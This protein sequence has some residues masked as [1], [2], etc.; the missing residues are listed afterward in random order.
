M[1]ATLHVNTSLARTA[2]QA[3]LPAAGGVLTR[4]DDLAALPGFTPAVMDRLRPFI[5]LLPEATAV[6]VNTAEAEVLTAVATLTLP[7][8]RQLVQA[9]AQAYFKDNS[10]FAL[11]LNDAQTLEG[12]RFDV[13]SEYFLVASE[14]RLK[15]TRLRTEALV[16]RSAATTLLWVR[17]S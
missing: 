1:L 12:V 10:D 15:G 14:V 2:A 13:T 17:E 11:R 3:L 6:N 16:R 7:Q 8:A 5:V 9:R 4:S